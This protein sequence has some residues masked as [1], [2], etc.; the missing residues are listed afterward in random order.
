MV[1]VPVAFGKLLELLRGLHEALP[2]LVEA[3]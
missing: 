1:V 3:D 2:L